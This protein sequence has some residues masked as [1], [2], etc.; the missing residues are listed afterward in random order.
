MPNFHRR[1]ALIGLGCLAIAA[2]CAP[3]APAPDCGDLRVVA[4]WVRL[5]PPGAPMRAAYF[6]LHN[7]GNRRVIVTGVTSPDFERVMMH[8]TVDRDGQA[9]MVH[10]DA[11]PIGPGERVAL[12]PGGAHLML[13]APP[14]APA[15]GDTVT[16]ELQC[17]TAGEATRRFEASYR[18]SPPSAS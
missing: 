4:P 16:F 18:R 1:A 14:E 10:L 5:P 9:T 6:E 2:G 13:S 11:L 8:E 17:G 7:P 3:G 12:R 15:A